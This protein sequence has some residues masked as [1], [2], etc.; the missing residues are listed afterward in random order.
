MS[1][2]TRRDTRQLS[3]V[4]IVNS[5]PVAGQHET[6]SSRAMGKR[7]TPTTPLAPE[8][9]GFPGRLRVAIQAS[10]RNQTDI[11]REAGTSPSGLSK[12]LDSQRP[13]MTAD[14]AIKLAKATGFSVGWLLT[15]QGA[16]QA[17][18][19]ASRVLLVADSRAKK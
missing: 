3:H 4:S 13:G 18:P 5:G 15:G 9:L 11:A 1:A 10:G 2:H 14:T 7:R 17:E 12:I 19:V 16:T 8:L 6:R